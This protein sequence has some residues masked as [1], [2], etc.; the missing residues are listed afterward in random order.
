MPVAN[1]MTL[2]NTQALFRVFIKVRSGQSLDSTEKRV[3]DM[4]TQMHQGEEDVT[5]RKIEQQEHTVDH[6]VA[7][8]DQRT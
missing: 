4:M 3:I 8:R 2:Y 7:D 1:A 6:G 5:V